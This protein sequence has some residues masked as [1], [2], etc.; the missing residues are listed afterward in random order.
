MARRK[1]LSWKLGTTQS[2]YTRHAEKCLEAGKKGEEL[3]LGAAMEITVALDEVAQ[4]ARKWN[5][6]I[7]GEGWS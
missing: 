4:I 3:P 2:R 1:P 7:N 6:K 5:Y